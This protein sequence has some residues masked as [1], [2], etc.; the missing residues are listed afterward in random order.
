MGGHDQAYWIDE[1]TGGVCY[2]IAARGL[3][4]IH[5]ENKEYWKWIV[6]KNCPGARSSEVAHLQKVCW[7][8]MG[9]FIDWP[10]LPGAYTLSWR[11][12]LTPQAYRVED[13]GWL[14]HAV[15]FRLGFMNT[16]PFKE[17][18]RYLSNEDGERQEQLGTNLTPVR[19]VGDNWFEYD[20]GEINIMDSGGN[21]NFSFTMTESN[22]HNNLWK[23]EL[24]MDGV[25][26]RPT[27]LAK[28]IGQS[29][30]IR[31]LAERHKNFVEQGFRYL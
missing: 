24:L 28:T 4:I 9:G 31:E 15:V 21:A 13:H 11:L 1:P 8:E 23:S 18:M 2:S 16:T 25:V 6:Q 10:L 14:K 29:L 3:Y 20:V 27:S 30:S 22:Q 12:Q 17:T 19:L 5:R 26:L 7:F